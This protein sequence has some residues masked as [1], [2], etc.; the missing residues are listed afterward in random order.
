[1][2]VAQEIAGQEVV[3]KSG[4]DFHAGIDP[5]HGSGPQVEKS[6]RRE[7][8]ENVFSGEFPDVDGRRQAFPQT[9]FRLQNSGRAVSLVGSRGAPEA[10]QGPPVA[11]QR[12]GPRPLGKAARGDGPWSKGCVAPLPRAGQIPGQGQG[13]DDS[14][15]KDFHRPQPPEHSVLVRPELDIAQDGR[16]PGQF[17]HGQ[18]GPDGCWAGRQPALL[19]EWVQHGQVGVRNVSGPGLASSGSRG[20]AEKH[21]QGCSGEFQQGQGQ[22]PVVLHPVGR[23]FQ[24]KHVHGQGRGLRTTAEIQEN[25]VD[26]PRPGPAQA[27]LLPAP[28]QALLVQEDQD[29]VPGGRAWFGEP[30]GA[31]VPGLGFPAIQKAQLPG[32]QGQ[33]GCAQ[34]GDQNLAQDAGGGWTA[35]EASSWYFFRL[36]AIRLAPLAAR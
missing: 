34:A 30:G 32:Q 17:G 3:Q 26:L 10:Q 2:G 7:A 11:V 36:P 18:T 21:G 5:A 24:K 35:H 15:V 4:L 13:R 22:G 6:G 16:R 14:A 9:Q 31:H 25:P 20:M 29:D 1:M 19:P 28:V 27:A 8:E 12:D 33:Q 23:R